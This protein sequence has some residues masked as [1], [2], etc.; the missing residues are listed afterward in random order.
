MRLCTKT[1]TQMLPGY[2]TLVGRQ[3]IFVIVKYIRLPQSCVQNTAADAARAY[4]D[5]YSSRLNFL[6]FQIQFRSFG[7]VIIVS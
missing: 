5:Q 1:Q 7:S 3:S 2:L 6:N 4:H